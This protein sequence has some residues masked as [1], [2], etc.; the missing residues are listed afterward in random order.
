MRK[1]STKLIAAL[2]TL[3]IVLVLGVLAQAGLRDKLKLDGEFAGGQQLT[4]Q[5][6]SDDPAKVAAA[7]DVLTKRFYGAGATAVETTV[8]DKTVVLKVSGIEDFTALRGLVTR[9]GKLTFRNSADEELMDA[10]V[11]DK[12][13]PLAVSKSGDDVYVSINVKDGATFKE[14]TAELAGSTNTMMVLWVDFEEGTDKYDTES[15]AENPSFLGAATVTSAIDSSCYITTHHTFEEA[16]DMAILVNSGTL[17]A[18]AVEKGFEAFEPKA[19]ASG[20]K[21]AWLLLWGG[22]AFLAAVLTVLYGLPGL[23]TGLY[24]AAF[25]A[26]VLRL[27]TMANAVFNTSTAAA[28]AVILAAGVY[29]TALVYEKFRQELLKGRNLNVSIK[30]A[31]DAF[32]AQLWEGPILMGLASGTAYLLFAET[33]GPIAIVCGIGSA[34][35]FVLFTVLNKYTVTSIIESNIVTNKDRYGIK[36]AQIPDV[37]KGETYVAPEARML[38]NLTGLLTGKGGIFCAVILAI[39]GAG[40]GLALSGF[41]SK[42]LLH[43][44]IIAA[45][46]VVLAE[47]YTRFLYRRQKPGYWLIALAGEL[48]AVIVAAL[49]GTD[50]GLPLA[51]LAGSLGILAVVLSELR[52]TYRQLAREKINDDKIRKYAEGALG[53]LLGRNIIAPLAATLIA[54]AA[55]KGWLAAALL[56]VIMIIVSVVAAANGMCSQLRASG[57]KT[58]K[59]KVKKN[60]GIKEN[61]IFGI[62]EIK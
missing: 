33:L 8:Q 14:K 55:V 13:Q 37:E 43:L 29:M 44:A 9:T 16:R 10:S 23:V 1:N 60:T 25:V 30:T 4:Y 12:D 62:N 61:T 45:I 21:T 28:L 51:V 22:T 39:A 46:I 41:G 58:P 31:Y 24:S 7:A 50:R 56:T 36:A 48:A 47:I 57:N 54:L 2:V 6:S 49:M 19:G 59:K 11:L 40:L 5:I 17:P 20:I 32:R 35:I 15:E 52:T 53:T 34:M 27:A 3:V 38:I 18:A 26:I 42:L